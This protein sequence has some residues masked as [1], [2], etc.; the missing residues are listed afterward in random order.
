[1]PYTEASVT[2]AWPQNA[3]FTAVGDTTVAFRHPKVVLNW[4]IN[5]ARPAGI[6]PSACPPV[7]PR[8]GASMELRD[9]ESLWLA[10]PGVQGNIDVVIVHGAA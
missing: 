9:G 3:T 5:G 8:I 10:A 6:A 4:M 7:D 1:M 2:A